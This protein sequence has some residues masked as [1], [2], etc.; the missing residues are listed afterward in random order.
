MEIQP[1]FYSKLPKDVVYTIYDKLVY[2]RTLPLDVRNELYIFQGISSLLL[3]YD[4]VYG[5]YQ[6]YSLLEH[7]LMWT[8]NDNMP[9]NKGVSPKL[10]E[11]YPK[12]T[13]T[14]LQRLFCLSQH[15][16]IF[17]IWSLMNLEKKIAILQSYNMHPSSHYS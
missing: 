12:M 14:Y 8:L 11:E 1:L 13:K 5:S 9:I 4:M 17:K 7:D 10:L 15:S 3:Y 16:S 6:G 2:N